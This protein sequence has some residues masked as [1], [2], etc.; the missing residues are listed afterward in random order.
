MPVVAGLIEVADAGGL[1]SY[2]PNRNEMHRRA[3]VFVDR[4]LKG[5]KLTD[6]PWEQASKLDLI[7]NL[8]TA[9]ALD[10]TIP[11]PM[12]LRADRTIE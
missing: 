11:P 9:R 10:L 12:L 1:M 6:L 7:I 8:K 4:L 2:G 5:T 3:A